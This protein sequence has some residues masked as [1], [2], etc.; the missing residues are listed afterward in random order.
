MNKKGNAMIEL[1]V[2]LVVVVITSAVV[3]VL[4]S[5]GIISVKAENEDV[6]LLNT[7]FIPFGQE[8]YLAVQNFQ[9]CDSV[10]VEYQCLNQ[11]DSF[12]LGEEVHFLFTVESSTHNGD[13]IIVENY[14]IKGPL[15]QLLLDVDAENDFYFDIKSGKATELISFK[16]YFVVGSSLPSGIYTL[17]LVLENPLIQKKA[18]VVKE[19][20]MV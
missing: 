10:N 5:S 9:F 19:F 13:V 4:I 18:T 1:L 16:D 7:E 6:S 15:G 3:L 8:G 14:R 17:E 20:E 11:K 12:V 2:V